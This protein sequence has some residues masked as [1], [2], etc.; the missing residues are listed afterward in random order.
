MKKNIS[1]NISGIIFHVEEDG[2]ERLK[3]YLESIN[4]YFETFEDS[5]EI[6][7]DIENRI[8]EIFLTKLKDGKQ[9]VNADDIDSLISTMGTISDFEAMEEE[10]T[11]SE[12]AHKKPAEEESTQQAEGEAKTT[13]PKK[14]YRD[15]RRRVMGGVAAG[16]AH[17]FQIDP[18][19]I[20]LLFILLFVNILLGG[21]SGI[22][23]IAYIILWIVVPA[24]HSLDEDNK[25]KKMFR[26]PDDRV[27][28]GVAGGIASYFGADATVI[29]LLFV[30][31]IFLGGTG[32]ILYV[33]LWIITP[34]AKSI[35]EKMQM[36][37]EPV[38]LSNI[39]QNVKKSLNVK[40]G[41]EST[42]VKILLFPF[43]IIAAIIQALGQILG[44]LLKFLLEAARILAGILLLILGSSIIV[45][46]TIVLGVA[47]GVY[48]GWTD[49]ISM[50]DVPIELIQN[51]FPAL[52]A[53]FIFLAVLIP[54]IGIA[55]GGI[56]IIAKRGITNAYI[57]WSMFGLWIISLIGIS[58]SAPPLI[59]GWTRDGQYQETRSFVMPADKITMLALRDLDKE[60]HD[61]VSLKIRGHADSTYLAELRFESR[62]SNREEAIQNAQMVT[63][64][65]D[66]Q[67]SVLYFD[68]NLAFKEDAIFRAQELDIILYVPFGSTFMMDPDL[69]E[70][71]RNTLYR[72]GYS[73]SQMEDNQWTTDESGIKCLT[74]KSTRSS[75]R[76]GTTIS[77]DEYEETVSYNFDDFDAIKA[78]YRY[79]LE[80]VQSNEYS[81]VVKAVDGK[82]LE[83]VEIDKIGDQ[84][85]FDF[86]DDRWNW[87]D[88]NDEPP[89]RVYITTPSLVDLY[90]SGACKATVNGFDEENMDVELRGASELNFNGTVEMLKL[91]LEGASKGFLYGEGK[92]IEAS[93][94]GASNLEAYEYRVDFA[95]LNASGA[96]KAR[97][98][99]K[100]GISGSSSGVADI[101]YRGTGTFQGD[102]D[103]ERNF[104]RN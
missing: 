53:I 80:I 46:I 36:Q 8:A 5:K 29:R 22:V 103:Q 11:F 98:Y 23:L 90:L 66:Q 20:R 25:I 57:G 51:T 67:D 16:I 64:G 34:E 44:P 96:S 77:E 13:G 104:R 95:E 61:A 19:W 50:G 69:E 40:E 31:S 62:G 17:Y 48:G 101:K 74:C 30:L 14:L 94:T 86:D 52:L 21:L 15:M 42:F 24:N 27:L 91:D 84:L 58:F 28:G 78:H 87:F 83:S 71:L 92:D 88:Q 89:I 97:V 70:I 37:G 99:V 100:R 49:F 32:L 60:Y 47:L 75:N 72:N 18:L 35:T 73:V 56:A 79:E 43:R 1:I 76:S 7:A 85:S 59:K 2:Y 41:E 3:N 45:A 26:N 54:G 33:I 68:S 93:L 12:E 102:R 9:V 81:V 55:L 39:E 82:V 6:I 38:T 65:I 4:Q 10:S 63:Y